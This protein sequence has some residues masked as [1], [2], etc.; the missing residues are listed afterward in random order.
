MT[1]TLFLR[2]LVLYAATIC[3]CEAWIPTLCDLTNKT[4]CVVTAPTLCPV[5]P[6][7][8][9]GERFACSI[10]DLRIAVAAA[11]PAPPAPPTPPA[12]GT[13]FGLLVRF[14][15]PTS[16]TTTTSLHPLLLSFH[17]T[18]GCGMD[19]SANKATCKCSPDI[20]CSLGDACKKFQVASEGV[21]VR[22][23]G[24][25]RLRH[26]NQRNCGWKSTA[27]SFKY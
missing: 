3:A 14:Y 1:T 16:T 21:I 19:E 25:S 5:N 11:P 10:V 27:S 23:V 2:V 4:A 7:L 20:P 26:F 22:R 9:N 13:Q 12:P 24:V 8:N 17:G 18:G 6:L 15:I